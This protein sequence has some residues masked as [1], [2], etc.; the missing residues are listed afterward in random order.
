MPGEVAVERRLLDARFGSLVTI[1]DVLVVPPIR[2]TTVEGFDTAVF[3]FTTDLPWLDRWG[4]PLLIGPGSV[5]VAHTA[6]E[7]VPI[8]ELA[9]A[10]DLYEALARKLLAQAG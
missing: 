1:E 5:T 2:L 6:D 10:V 4:A 3:S 8:S 9:R 7:H